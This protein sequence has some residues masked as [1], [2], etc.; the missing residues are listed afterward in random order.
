[1]SRFGRLATAVALTAGLL[2]VG[3]PAQAA[4]PPPARAVVLT[5]SAQ[6]AVYTVKAS[7]KPLNPGNPNRG[8]L[9]AVDAAGHRQALSTFKNAGRQVQLMGSSLIQT[10][11]VYLPDRNYQEVHWLDLRSGRTG[12]IELSDNDAGLTAAPGGFVRGHRT[13]ETTALGEPQTLSLQTWDGAQTPLGNPYPEGLGYSLV[14]GDG[15][16][17]ASTATS[18]ETRNADARIRYMSWSALGVWRTLYD[19]HGERYV[20]C[21]APSRTHVV[22]SSMGLDAEVPQLGLFRLKDGA[23]TW[24]RKVHPKVCR[25]LDWATSGA[26]LVAIERSDAGVCTRGKLIRFSAS[27]ALVGSARRY[28]ALGGVTVGLGR[29]L[30]SR[31][32]QRV[33]YSLTGVTRTPTVLVPRSVIDRQG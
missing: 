22:C 28:S 29:I 2:A 10:K 27:G 11:Q 23:V 17:L 25:D 4:A 19:A 15:G 31:D 24:L 32:D 6:Y 13:G 16:L 33:L 18:D 20:G 1:M 12:R 8:K 30:V 7:A 5:A 21:S 3:A 14:A 9:Y 26:N